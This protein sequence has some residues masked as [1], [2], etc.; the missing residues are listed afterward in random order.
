MRE[1]LDRAGAWVREE[2]PFAL[3]VLVSAYASAPRELGAS[4]IV[5]AEGAVFGNVSAGCVDGAVH[6][7]CTQAI[8]SG[9]VTR[10]RYGIADDQAFA[11]GL[12]CGGVIDVLVIPVL[13]GSDAASALG[14]LSG[15]VARREACALGIVTD[16]DHGGALVFSGGPEPAPGAR[17]L[18]EAPAAL[19]A[20]L[21]RLRADAAPIRLRYPTPGGEL[22]VLGLPFGHPPRLI[23]V[24]AVEFSVA[25]SRL[26][27]ASGFEV[28]VCDPRDVFA[29]AERFPAASEISHRWPHEYLAETP[30]DENAAICVL[31]HDDR[32]D[33]PALAVALRSRAGYVGAMG[34]RRTHDDRARRLREAGV[35]DVEAARLRSP[36]GLAL[37]GRTPE[38]TALSILAEIVMVRA[39][40]NGAPLRG[41]SG[42]VHPGRESEGAL[43]VASGI[44]AGGEDS[45]FCPPEIDA[46]IARWDA[47]GRRR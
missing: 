4:M 3:A 25:L 40:G 16:G 38:E 24:G 15:S 34:S 11:A 1:I 13:P 44:A 8:D 14:R 37:G 29:S 46:V 30:I 33:V 23:I 7:L 26:G 45:A 27:A 41:Q 47:A 32:F 5:D 17:A 12:T 28:T 10:A 2:R 20:D 43:G 35:T 39:G 21:H 31:T 22:E 9:D 6:D 19:A 18:P 42:P 36:I